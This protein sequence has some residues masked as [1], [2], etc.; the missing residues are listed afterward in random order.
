MLLQGAVE[1]AGAQ[2]CRNAATPG[3]SGGGRWEGRRSGGERG[4]GATA[5]AGNEPGQPSSH[6]ESDAPHGESDASHG[7]SDAPHGESDASHGESDASH[8][9]SDASHGESDASHGESDASHGESDASHGESD[10]LHGASK[11]QLSHFGERFDPT[12]CRRSCGNCCQ[13]TRFFPFLPPVFVPTVPVSSSP[14]S[15]RL[16]PHFPHLLFPLVPH[17]FS[18]LSLHSL[19]FCLLPLPFPLTTRWDTV[20]TTWTVGARCSSRI[21]GSALIPRTAAAPATTA[22]GTLPPLPGTS[23]AWPCVS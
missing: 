23:P 9:E 16:C 4:H 10:A 14:F 22:A 8:G 13:H 15:P 21:L 7:E 6:G 19:P 17:S 11:E 3:G 2:S 18:P 20:R 5:A 12:H 1:V